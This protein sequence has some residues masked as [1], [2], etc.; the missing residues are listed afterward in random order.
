MDIGFSVFGG[1]NS[2][3]SI[4]LQCDLVRG[5]PGFTLIF[6][7]VEC[8]GM[9]E[10]YFEYEAYRTR[11]EIAAHL[12][13]IADELD[14][15]GPIT[16]ASGSHTISVTPPE[17]PWFELEVERGDEVEI[18]IELEW[19]SS[20]ETRS[21]TELAVELAT[22][23]EQADPVPVETAGESAAFE[24]YEDRADKWRF[25]LVSDGA[26]LAN[27]SGGKGSREAAERAIETIQRIAAEAAIEEE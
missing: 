12:R 11:G 14:G 5:W 23:D 15:G 2:L 20:V 16:F 9:A 10:E 22:E 27:S 18:E 6:F 25:R 21:S 26:I 8:T 1:P 3:L 7:R 17:R 19:D 24:L 4:R 13:E